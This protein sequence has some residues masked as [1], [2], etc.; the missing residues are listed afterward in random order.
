MTTDPGIIALWL[1]GSE[2][3][4]LLAVA[5]QTLEFDDGQS[6]IFEPKRAFFLQLLQTL[7]RILPGDAGERPDLFLGDFQ[8]A[9]QIRIENWIEQ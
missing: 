1:P 6:A 3:F 5:A 8:M 9:C 7:V 4:W 2:A